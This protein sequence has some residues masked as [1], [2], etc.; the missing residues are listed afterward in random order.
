ML[1]R[2]LPSPFTLA[3]LAALACS[4]G[5]GNPSPPST[6][7]PTACQ[8]ATGFT[9]VVP[10][11]QLGYLYAH[12]SLALGPRD[13]PLVA[14]VAYDHEDLNAS[15][16]YFVAYDADTCT[17]KPPVKVDQVEDL[18]DNPT[19]REVQLV[20]DASTGHLGLAY[21]VNAHLPLP[22]GD[23]HMMLAHSTDGGATWTKE[24][25][26]H[27][28][29]PGDDNVYSLAHPTVAMAA[30]K[31]FY[32]YYGHYNIAPGCDSQSQCDA[33]VVLS[34]TGD[35]GAFT[36]G[37]VQ[38]AEGDPGAEDLSGALAADS[39]GN[40]GFLFYSRPSD[41]SENLLLNYLRVGDVRASRVF[42]SLGTQN[43]EPGLT[44]TFEGGQPRVAASLM[45]SVSDPGTSVWFSSSPDGRSWSAPL[46]MPMDGGNS[47]GTYLSIASNGKGQ[48]TIAS[49]QTGGTDVL[50]QCGAPKLSTSNDGTTWSTCGAN[51]DPTNELGATGYYIQLAYASTGKRLAA[52]NSSVSS[53]E[54]EAGVVVW[55]EP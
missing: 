33:W 49:A 1:P 11:N 24:Q 52:F 6:L 18:T 48:L 4:S 31:T 28:G 39:Q 42:D 37:I 15:S 30:G 26:A 5:C 35:S 53:P 40:A 12:E 41:S 50:G 23:T 17:W 51:P 38:S 9:T 45:R 13:E 47:M 3:L 14:F 19:L 20:R 27:S 54:L 29:D 32:A 43:D 36:G 55:R 10:L 34:R 7:P 16:L 22:N 21:E 2:R 25:V 46:E 8:P 44:L